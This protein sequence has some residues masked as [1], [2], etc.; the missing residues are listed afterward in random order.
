MATLKTKTFPDDK[1]GRALL[2]KVQRALSNLTGI[3]V[4]ADGVYLTAPRK[5]DAD[6]DMLKANYR[7]VWGTCTIQYDP[8]EKGAEAAPGTHDLTIGPFFLSRGTTVM[9]MEKVLLHEYLHL[10]IDIS[11]HATEAEH[12]QINHIIRDNLRYPGSPNPANPSED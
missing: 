2:A 1:D 3:G 7:S 11:W 9:D 8:D 6:R 12:G 10:V 5:L 4:P